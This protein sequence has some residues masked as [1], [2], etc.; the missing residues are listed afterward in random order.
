MTQ[1]REEEGVYFMGLSHL[2]MPRVT[3]LI[4]NLKFHFRLKSL[5]ISVHRRHPHP[6]SKKT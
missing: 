6:H 5:T 1:S 4:N 3:F 2:V